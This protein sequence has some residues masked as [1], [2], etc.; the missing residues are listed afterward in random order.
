MFNQHSQRDTG[1]M[2]WVHALCLIKKIMVD[3]VVSSLVM[4]MSRFNDYY[5]NF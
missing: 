2:A 1:F 5:R 3:L 4:N